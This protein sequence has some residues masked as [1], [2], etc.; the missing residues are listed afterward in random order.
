MALTPAEKAAA[1]DKYG[2]WPSLP[3]MAMETLEA[4]GDAPFLWSKPAGAEAFQPQTF[5]ET[6]RRII[7]FAHGL[8]DLGLEPGDRVLLASENRPEWLIADTAIMLAGG[9][10]VPAYVTNGPDEHAY[11]LQDSGAV[12]IIVS[13]DKTAAAALSGAADADIRF[14]IAMDAGTGAAHAFEDVIQR[15]AHKTSPPETLSAIGRNDLSSLIYT[16]GTGGA[17]KGVMLSHRAIFANCKSALDLVFDLDEVK[18]PR[19][20][21]FLSFLPLSHAYERTCGQFFP[22][23]AGCQIYY[24]ESIERLAGNLAETRPTIMTA[25]PR[26]YESLHGRITSGLRKESVLKQKLFGRAVEL[27]RKRMET[28]GVGL[29]EMAEDALLERLVREK[30]RQR[31]GGRLKALIS[32]GA[33]LNYDIGMFFSALGLRLLQGYG[34]TECAPVA[35]CNRPA[36]VDLATV[37]PKLLGVDVRIAE[38]GEILLAGD[39]L[40]DGYWNRPEDTAAT[41]VDGWLHTGDVGEFDEAG[42]LKITDRKKDIIVNAGGDNVSP[43]RIEGVLSIEPEIDQAMVFGDKRPHLVALIVPGEEFSEAFAK[44]HGLERAALAE[45]PAFHAAI[46]AAVDRAN[47]KLSSIER[48]RRFAFADEPF[49]TENGLMTPT[50]KIRRRYIVEAYKSRLDDLYGGR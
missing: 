20:E 21:A 31:F 34:Q 25:V 23:S 1:L 45:D 18:D 2:V 17:P 6:R 49:T 50:M 11:V 42:R 12:G 15:H 47:G 7:A 33:P 13:G 38:D 37:G 19:E 16:S 8:I 5:A 36:S 24:A 39:L 3:A 14:S 40:M 44:E 28:G 9:V 30:V 41:I 46:V 48:I 22:M 27:G 4:G 35:T 10:T 32:G 29:F 43:Q 26:L